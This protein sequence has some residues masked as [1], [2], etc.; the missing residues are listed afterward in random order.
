MEDKQ[1]NNSNQGETI[2]NICHPGDNV[3]VRVLVPEK[4]GRKEDTGGGDE[5]AAEN[6]GTVQIHNR[7]DTRLPGKEL[8]Q[9][10]KLINKSRKRKLTWFGHV[11]RMEGS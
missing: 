6:T 4:K 9:E 10:I 11:T 8:G 1:D 2:R 5:L 3:R 7:Q